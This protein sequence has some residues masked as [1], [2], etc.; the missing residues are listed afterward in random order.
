[1]R[2]GSVGIV[3]TEYF[4]YEGDLKLECGKKLKNI[5]IAYETYGK[6]NKEK[7]NAILICHA[8]S[9]DAHA[10]GKHTRDDKKPGWWDGVI[11]PGKAFD[12][13]KYFVICSNVIGGCKGSTGPSSI[14]PETGK[15]Y[16]L[17]FPIV[18]IKD[19]VNAQKLLLEH[20]GID[21][22]YAVAGGSMGGMQ[23]LQWAVSYPDMVKIVIAIATTA[24]ASPQQIAF[25]EVGRMAIMTDP[26]WKN[27][28]YYDGE[29]PK[30]GLAIARMIGHITYLSDE[31]MHEKFG[32][33][34][35]NKDMYDFN[36]STEFQVESYLHY[37]GDKFVRRF[38]ANS[39]LYITKAIDYF[40]LTE[41]GK[42]S[43]QDVFKKVN[44]RFL[45]VSISSDW[46]YPPYQSEEL[47]TA[48][49]ANDIDVTYIEMKSSYGHDAFLVETGQMNYII[50]N[51]LS[52]SIVGDIMIKDVPTLRIGSTIEEAAKLMI[53][54]GKTHIVVVAEDGRMVGV[55][56]AW[57]LSKAI[58]EKHRC[59]NEIMTKEVICANQKD[60]IKNAAEKMERYDISAMPVIDE[61][62]R[63]IGLITSDSIARM[64]K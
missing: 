22:L 45:I 16:G 25:N 28:D 11:G 29:P 39:Y 3:K 30:N 49:T 52:K 8:L 51:Y 53:E 57:D 10:A 61:E 17:S 23:A 12:T 59:I 32:R 50:S 7:S 56:T 35:Q 2:R 38:D 31:S 1:M 47:V 64:V 21:H 24:R 5:R 19:M 26:N 55:V 13:R 14:N 58:V 43:L 27:G 33:R 9:G 42:K 34:L 54:K 62:R 48:L 44:S 46:L 41:G 18:T 4:D 40:D 15:R 6:P 36:F 37:K 20:L 63:V 60:S